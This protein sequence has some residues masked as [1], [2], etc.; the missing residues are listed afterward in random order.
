[1]QAMR[2]D[3]YIV[4]LAFVACLLSCRRIPLY[5]P[6]SGVYLKLSL[7]LQ[8]QVNVPVEIDLPA[9]PELD[10]KVHIKKPQS[11]HVC[12]YDTGTHKLVA[13]DYLDGEGGFI[14]LAPGEYDMIVYGLGC[15]VT[16]VEQTQSRGMAYAFTSSPGTRVKVSKAGA[17]DEQT[18]FDVIYEP[19]HLLA[20][21]LERMVIPVHPAGE[22]RVIVI[23][24][25]MSTLLET[26]SFRMPNVTGLEHVKSVDVYIT[27]QAPS[28][29]LWDS[30]YPS[31]AVAIYFPGVFGAERGIYSIFNTFGRFPEFQNKAYVYMNFTSDGGGQFQFV[32]DVTDQFTDPDNTG[33]EIVIGDVIDIP[34]GGAG[35]GTGFMPTVD[36][37]N[38]EVIDI[39]LS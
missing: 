33:H 11:V 14:H 4:L 26:Y 24:D 20:G 38:V 22:E 36:E 1:M 7:E 39:P 9:H 23:E 15:E 31:R 34:E 10:A 27:G 37:W 12:F 35:S 5:D 13:E 6:D 3:K 29:Y 8:A 25:R 17:V 28:R 32:R 2:M 18:E 16:Q 30:R 21:R 19:D